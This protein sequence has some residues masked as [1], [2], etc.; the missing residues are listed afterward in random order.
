MTN[1]KHFNY[2]KVCKVYYIIGQICKIQG[3]DWLEE[4]LLNQWTKMVLNNQDKDD[5]VAFILAKYSFLDYLRSEDN[6]MSKAPITAFMI[7]TLQSV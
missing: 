5:E 3:L 7:D 1:I 4:I 6:T 2:K